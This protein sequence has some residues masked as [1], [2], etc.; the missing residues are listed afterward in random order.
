MTSL[1]RGPLPA[2]VYWRRR[3]V[4]FGAPL[5]LVVVLAQVL[6][7]SSDGSSDE[8]GAAAVVAAD[9]TGSDAT[10]P[11]ATEATPKQSRKPK[12]RKSREPVLAEPE[13]RCNGSDIV[14]TPAVEQAVAGQDVTIRLA[15][16]TLESPACLWRVSAQ[17]LTLKITSGPDFVWSSQQCRR[18]VPAREVVVRNNADTPVEVV[19]ADAKR[20]DD[21]CSQFTEWA[22]PGWYHVSAAALAG[23][24]SDVQFELETPAAPQ[25]TKT[26]KPKKG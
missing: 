12:A 18:A 17:N 7:G 10:E 15:L 3:L 11:A 8:P 24:P 26:A 16:R 23:E 1:T 9:P 20:S 21:E 2:S 13:G 4:V 14:V 25:V 22:L 6:G 5:A 19:W